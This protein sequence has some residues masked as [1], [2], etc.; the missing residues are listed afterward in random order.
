VLFWYCSQEVELN[1]F[2][3]AYGYYHFS[4]LKQTVD[5]LVNI[6]Q[7]ILGGRTVPAA[8]VQNPNAALKYLRQAAKQY[9]SIVPGSAILVD[10]TFDSVDAVFETHREQATGI[11]VAAYDRVRE[12]QQDTRIDNWETS[13]RIMGILREMTISLLILGGKAGDDVL[14]PVWERFPDVRGKVEKSVQDL[15]SFGSAHGPVAMKIAE[16]THRQVSCATSS[17]ECLFIA[18][19]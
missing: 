17:V 5:S 2:F 3:Q 7:R 14:G 11:V 9:A 16:D 13:A 18:A 19:R 4:G 6:K 1:K 12:V 15:I 10:M 8:A